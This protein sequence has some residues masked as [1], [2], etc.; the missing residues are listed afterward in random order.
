MFYSFVKWHQ[1]ILDSVHYDESQ[2]SYI[3]STKKYNLKR[4]TSHFTPSNTLVLRKIL[5]AVIYDLLYHT[6]DSYKAS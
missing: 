4:G 3:I 2:F 1:I 5:Q 6:S